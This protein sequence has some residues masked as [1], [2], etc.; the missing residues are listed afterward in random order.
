MPQGHAGMLGALGVREDA[1][2]PG[3]LGGYLSTPGMCRDAGCLG[4]AGMLGVPGVQRD[5]E[6]PRDAGMLDTPGM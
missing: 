4:D 6:H 2:C 1:L 3:D 5:G